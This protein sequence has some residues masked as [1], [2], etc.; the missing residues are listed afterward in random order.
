VRGDR[1]QSSDDALD[2]TISVA[3]HV[4]VPE[5]K[6]Q[7]SLCFED[8]GSL[9]ILTTQFEVLAAIELDNQPRRFAAEVHHIRGYRHLPTEFQS[10]EPA[11]AQ[12]KPQRALGIRLIAP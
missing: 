11:V 10:I 7:I 4:V 3:K 12:S 2:N 6:Y 8:G 9:G 1:S 5:A